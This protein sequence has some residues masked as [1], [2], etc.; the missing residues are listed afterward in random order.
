MTGGTV[1]GSIYGG[2]FTGFSGKVVSNVVE[3]LG[4]AIVETNVYGGYGSNGDYQSATNNSHTIIIGGEAQIKGTVYGYD[5]YGQITGNTVN[6]ISQ[7][8]RIGVGIVNA[9]TVNFENYFEETLD[10]EGRPR[11]NANVGTLTL[12]DNTVVSV[13]E[14]SNVLFGGKV[15]EEERNRDIIAGTNLTKSGAGILTLRG[16]HTY[17]G[18]TTL[19]EGLINFD[20]IATNFGTNTGDGVIFL[21]GGGLQWA[22]DYAVDLGAKLNGAITNGAI[23]DTNGNDVTLSTKLTGTNIKLVKAGDGMPALMSPVWFSLGGCGCWL[24]ARDLIAGVWSGVCWGAWGWF[25]AYSDL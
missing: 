17:T 24:L 6:K 2:Y 15:D 23:F 16:T 9:Q 19:T 4:D 8:S 22:T 7:E 12:R 14:K 18:T 13:A 1:Q 25:F 20:D 5:G 11:I 3:I 21:K 10:D